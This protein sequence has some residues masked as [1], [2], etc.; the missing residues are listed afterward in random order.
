[1]VTMTMGAALDSNL[2]SGKNLQTFGSDP[3]NSPI[4]VGSFSGHKEPLS[5]R[6]RSFGRRERRKAECG[7]L[8]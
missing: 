1:M 6:V 4:S 2:W 7:I 5:S 3:R 8:V